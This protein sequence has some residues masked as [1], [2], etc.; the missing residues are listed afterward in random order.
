MF[1]FLPNWKFSF[2]LMSLLGGNLRQRERSTIIHPSATGEACNLE[3]SEAW[4]EVRTVRL[5]KM[6]LV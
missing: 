3:R 2:N 5:P 6:L 4:R 1:L